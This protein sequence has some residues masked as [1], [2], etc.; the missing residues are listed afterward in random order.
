[1]LELLVLLLPTPPV[2]PPTIAD[3]PGPPPVADPI[4]LLRVDVAGASMLVLAAAELPGPPPVSEPLEMLP[5][6]LLGLSLMVLATADPPVLPPVAVTGASLLPHFTLLVAVEPLLMM[7]VS[8][9][10]VPR[11]RWLLALLRFLLLYMRLVAC[12]FAV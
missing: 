6:A 5:V 9:P 1:M 12:L 10:G 8:G 7:P 4:A 11:S 3:M 2:P